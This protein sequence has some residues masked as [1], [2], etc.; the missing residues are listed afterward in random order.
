MEKTFS[1]QFLSLYDLFTKSDLIK[2]DVCLYLPKDEVWTLETKCLLIQDDADS[3]FEEI[4][5]FEGKQMQYALQAGD[6]QQII[7][8]ANAQITNLNPSRLMKAFLFYY[9]RDAFIDFSN[10]IE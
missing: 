9:D 5:S 8:N 3:E 10:E 4:I 1:E 6:F 2:E 7:A